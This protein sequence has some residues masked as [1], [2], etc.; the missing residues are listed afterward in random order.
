[1]WNRGIKFWKVQNVWAEFPIDLRIAWTDYG[2]CDSVK[3]FTNWVRFSHESK[4]LPIRGIRDLC[5]IGVLKN[6]LRSPQYNP[7]SSFRLLPR[8]F[9]LFPVSPCTR[10]QMWWSIHSRDH[11]N[12]DLSSWSLVRL[13]SPKSPSLCRRIRTDRI[14]KHEAKL[15]KTCRQVCFRLHVLR[16]WFY[17]VWFFTKWRKKK[18]K[19][20]RALKLLIWCE[21]WNYVIRVEYCLPKHN[22]IYLCLGEIARS[23]MQNASNGK[24]F[25]MAILFWC[26]NCRKSTNV[27]HVH[28]CTYFKCCTLGEVTNSKIYFII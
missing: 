15:M 25:F 19:N 9:L 28:Y 16:I 6:H 23:M 11:C 18:K 10:R 8:S 12:N 5:G 7:V 14:L 20:F 3:I 21:I 26:P 27:K 4:Y 24:Y 22:L 13:S 2:Q 1:M 17:Q